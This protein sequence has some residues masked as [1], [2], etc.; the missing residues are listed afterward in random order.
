MFRLTHAIA[1]LAAGATY[2]SAQTSTECNPL[3]KTCPQDPALGTTF[4][5]TFNESMSEFDPNLFNI[6]AG[7][8][9]IEFNEE[10][11]QLTISASGESVTVETAFYIFW[12][13]V[14][15]LFKAA[16]GQGII[17]TLVLLSDDLDEIDWEIKGGNTSSVTCNYFGWGNTSQYNSEFIP[18]MGANW[19]DQGAMGDVHNYT[20]VWN[21]DQLEWILDGESV[22]TA[23]YQE[24]GLWPQTP[25]YLKFG[26]WAAGD[27][28]TQPKGTVKWAGGETDWD[29]G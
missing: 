14:E 25:S 6:T 19:G 8:D 1:L 21:Q 11:A 20:V 12:G 15:L 5:T 28:E 29:Q 7:Q 9:L 16:K 24:A 18:T 13:S 3:N 4:S 27:K 26:I 2:V 17:S 22:R 23:P 10:G